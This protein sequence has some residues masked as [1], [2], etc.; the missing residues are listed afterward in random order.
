MKNGTTHLFVPGPTNI[1]EA[2]RRAMNVSMQDMRAPDFPELVLPLFADLKRIFKTDTGTVFIFPGS[3]TGAW[4]AA[5]SNTLN[6]GDRVL[7]SRFGQFSHLWVDMAQRLGLDVECIDVE[8]GEGV[9]VEEYQRRLSDDKGHK[10]KAVFVTH[11]E[12]ATGVT[13]DVAGV[14]AAL[15]STGH[16]ALLFVDGVSSIGSIDFRMDAWGVDLAITGSQKGLMLPAGLGILAASEKALEAHK[17][18]RMERCYF[19][20]EDMK[21]PSA[22]GY[23]PYTPPTQLLHGLRASLD[24]IFAEGL[25]NVIARHHRLAEGV[26]RGVH[27]W[28]LRL[29]AKEEKWWSD[30]VSAIVVPENIDAR[31]VI[32]NG[33]ARYRTS[34]G[35]GLS[36]VAGRVF[37]IGHLGD[38]N[39]VMCLAALAS[40]EMSLRDAGSRI[41]AG[42]GVAAA[43]EWYR[44]EIAR[45][46]QM[47]RDRAA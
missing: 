19:S 46:E 7:M 29:C 26:R 3:G 43:Q 40:A 9:P 8:W 11:N 22:T 47:L 37:R 12:T 38:L 42:S 16:D 6:R 23:F 1:P 45:N 33:Y 5:I 20:F 4:E 39:E 13:S 35:A 28:G 14:R 10:I 36:K 24:L 31:H 17:Q 34:F 2:V 18:S 27:A 30:T 41:E 21:A 32:A 44:S 25:D 15:D